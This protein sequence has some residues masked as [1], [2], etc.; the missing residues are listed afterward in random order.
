[1]DYSC[2]GNISCCYNQPV[3]FPINAI[4]ADKLKE[5]D[6]VSVI[7]LKTRT[8]EQEKNLQSANNV[9][10]FIRELGEINASIG[11]KLS[12]EELESDFSETKENFEQRIHSMLDKLEEDCQLYADITYGPKPLPM[13]LMCAFTFAEKFFNADIKNIVYGKV[14]FIKGEDGKEKPDNPE[15]Y[16]I[17]SLYYL[18]NLTSSMEAPN[19]ETALKMLDKFFAL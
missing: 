11:A 19:A 12:Y 10:E 9:A 3:I 16:D 15:L 13:I 7:L 18:N 4:L 1:M 17:A 8:K 14:E 2:N 6:E 5:K